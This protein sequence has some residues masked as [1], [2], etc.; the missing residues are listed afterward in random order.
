LAEHPVVVREGEPFLRTLVSRLRIGRG[1]DVLTAPG[2]VLT[3][4]GKP[5]RERLTAPATMFLGLT[6]DSLGYFV[7]EDEWMTGRNEGYEE[8][9]SLG[10][11]AAPS[12]EVATRALLDA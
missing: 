4:L 9:V 8:T 6:N 11:R 2:E 12:L 10:P 1:L 7:P 5:L 3:R